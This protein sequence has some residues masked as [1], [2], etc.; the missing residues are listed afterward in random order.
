MGQQQLLLIILGVIIVGVAL[1]VGI[2]MYS[3]HSAESKRNLVINECVNLGSDAQ[4]YYR[5]PVALG[6][7]EQSFTGWTIPADLVVTASGS[8]RATVFSDSI[9]IIGTGNQVVADNDSVKVRFSIYSDSYNTS[10]I[11]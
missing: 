4:K 5:K 11:N 10:I 8:Y 3:A 1:V 2:S 7:G 9:V 6:G